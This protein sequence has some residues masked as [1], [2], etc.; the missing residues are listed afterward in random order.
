MTNTY[1][2]IALFA[3]NRPRHTAMVLEALAVNP[4]ARSSRLYVFHDGLKCDE[5]AAGWQA[6]RELLNHI[7]GFADVKIVTRERNFGLADSIC[8]GVG[9]TVAQHGRI[10]VLEDDLVVSPHF[11]RYL[12]QALDRYATDERVMQVSAYNYPGARPQ[13]LPDCGFVRL[14]TCWGWATWDRAWAHFQRSDALVERFNAEMIRQFTMDHAYDYFWHQLLLNR[15]GR[16]RTWF[17]YWYASMFLAQGLALFPRHSL[18]ANIGFDGSGQHCAQE[19]GP[20]PDMPR[21][22]VAVEVFPESVEPSEI[23]RRH[24]VEQLRSCP[25][26]WRLRLKMLLFR[27]AFPILR[28]LGAEILLR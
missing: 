22:D 14:A 15:L 5:H 23:Y 3:Y 12:N 25:P 27:Q 1:A 17:I 13:D 16:L 19:D 7:H 6:V 26:P 24:I 18:V 10:I 20:A 28:P 21:D 4:E 9:R 8:D 11:L 2:P